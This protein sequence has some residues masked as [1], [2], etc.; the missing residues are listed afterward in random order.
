MRSAANRSPFNGRP[1]REAFA[2]I[3]GRIRCNCY[4]FR[5]LYWEGWSSDRCARYLTHTRKAP[6]SYGGRQ[7][8]FLG[9]C[10]GRE[11][12]TSCSASKFS[13]HSP[14]QTGELHLRRGPLRPR[15]TTA[16]RDHERPVGVVTFESQPLSVHRGHVPSGSHSRRRAQASRVRVLKERD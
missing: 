13:D 7:A 15:R 14:R 5:Y 6:W 8:C 16:S 3:G 12:S 2:A 1:S 9:C 10:S 4:A 11:S